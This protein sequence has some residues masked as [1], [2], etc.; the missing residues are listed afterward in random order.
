VA[1]LGSF[2]R[3]A[4]QL[5][6]SQPAVSQ[7]I[8]D[9]EQQI[10]MVLLDRSA[11]PVAL[12]AAGTV[13]FAYA[14]RIAAEERAAERALNQLR[15]LDQGSI[16]VGASSTIGIYLLPPLIAR[17]HQRYPAVRLFLDIGN[18]QQI[19]QHLRAATLDVAFVEGPVDPDGL[20]VVPWQRDELMVIAPPD[21]PLVQAKTVALADLLAEPFVLR[22]QGSGTRE[23][24]EAALRDHGVTLRVP[25]E[26]G[27]TEA[28][29]RAVAAGMGLAIVSQAT[30]TSE[31]VS[32][33]LCQLAVPELTLTRQLTRLSVVGRPLSPALQTWLTWA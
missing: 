26:L 29:K 7:S 1:E 28:I 18:T 9:L 8:R 19:V 22:E 33:Q 32:G 13:L 20:L 14:Q 21:H 11:R 12:T 24:I 17:F 15:S 31:L 30:V 6:I 27:S 23:V 25:L 16:A 4:D 5:F 2:S 10:G 3:A